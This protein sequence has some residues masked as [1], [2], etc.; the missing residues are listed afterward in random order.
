MSAPVA[1]KRMVLVMTRLHLGCGRV[2]LQG[3]INID[4]DFDK[5]TVQDDLVADKY[6]NV[7][8]LVYPRSTIEEIRLHHVFEHFSRPVA[9]ALLCRWRDWLVSDGKLRIET[10]DLMGAARCLAS[11]FTSY[12]VRQEVVRHL[13]GSHEAMWAAHWDGWYKDRFKRTLDLL[14]FVDLNFSCRK[15]GALH[16]IEVV[17][18]RGYRD[19]SFAE[20]RDLVSTLLSESLICQPGGSEVGVSEEA[21]LKVWLADWER[22]Y[23]YGVNEG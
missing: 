22:A 13:F 20:Y 16:N 5:H 17:A 10:P 19:F 15:W 14:G 2:Y 23:C 9:L 6:C 8:G 21:M 1:R 4:F 11:P 12:G 3:Y 7:V 18:V